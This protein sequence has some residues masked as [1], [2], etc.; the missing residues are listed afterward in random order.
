VASLPLRWGDGYSTPELARLTGLSQRQLHWL[1]V[2]GALRPSVPARG[3]G[4]RRRYSE[5]DAAKAKLAGALRSMGAG[6]EVIA[7]A[8]DQLPADPDAWSPYLFVSPT[9][10]V[11]SCWPA[12]PCWFGVSVARLLAGPAQSVDVHAVAV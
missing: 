6:T 4:T 5:A 1:D 10:E 2:Q 11:R 7:A 3:S 9:G 8:L 12:G